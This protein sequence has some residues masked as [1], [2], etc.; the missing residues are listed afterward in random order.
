MYERRND[1]THLFKWLLS[2]CVT[3]EWYMSCFGISCVVGFSNIS[4]FLGQ[5]NG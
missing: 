4:Y 3:T 2:I 5:L 1:R